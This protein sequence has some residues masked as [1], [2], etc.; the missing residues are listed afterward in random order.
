MRYLIIL[1]YSFF[2]YC[3]SYSQLPGKIHWSV[4]KNII[5]F[6]I[7]NCSNFEMGLDEN[8]FLTKKNN[9][10]F[11][12]LLTNEALRLD[13]FQVNKLYSFPNQNL[14][15]LAFRKRGF[16]F[17]NDSVSHFF[18]LQLLPYDD[19]YLIAYKDSTIE[20]ISGNFFKTPISRYYELNSDN[21]KTYYEFLR[22]KTFYI[23]AKDFHFIKKDKYFMNFKCYSDYLK[24]E[25]S[26]KMKIKDPEMLII[27]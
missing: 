14:K 16:Q 15:L 27:E 12:N 6:H 11:E 3:Q 2:S 19:L 10:L 23:L 8:G 5:A 26:I 1:L 4:Q 22:L 9:L 13:S 7:R 18:D 17:D 21:P 25:I 24:R 20:Y